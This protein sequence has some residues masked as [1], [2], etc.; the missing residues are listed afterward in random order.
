MKSKMNIAI[1]FGGNSNEKDISLNTGKSV[2][3]SLKHEYSIFPIIFNRDYDKLLKNIKKKRIDLVFNALHGGDGEN[4]VIQQFLDNNEIKYTGSG[5]KSS[6]IAM[7][8]N[9]TKTL[10]SLNNIPTPKW[11]HLDFSKDKIHQI[12]YSKIL[13]FFKSGC[14]IK[15]SDGGSSVGMSIINIVSKDAISVAI[16]KS[17]QISNKVIIE[18]YIEGKELTVS[19]LNNK[20]LPTVEI[21][22]KGPFYD[23]NSK[24]IKGQSSYSIFKNSIIN[25]VL[26]EYALQINKIIGC[27]HYCRVDFRLDL[28]NNVFLLEL[29]TLPGLTETS[30]F[31]KSAKADN[32]SYNELINKIINLAK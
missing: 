9:T 2:I 20:C 3:A 31:P 30:L 11:I 21:F 24:Y 1:I 22:P 28:N 4:G 10:C 7:D 5:A 19:I 26:K 8:K 23:Y 13:K 27:S 29:N 17:L 32:I 15:P 6:R 12:N 16:D 25:K 18:E 14:V